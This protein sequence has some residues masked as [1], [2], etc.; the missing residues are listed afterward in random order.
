MGA[1]RGPG[2]SPV[3]SARGKEIVSVGRVSAIIVTR[4][5]RRDIGRTLASVSASC[6]ALHEVIVLDHGSSDGTADYVRCEHRDVVLLDF[7]DNPG[8]GEGNNRGAR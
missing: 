8:F 2:R 7:L 4:N 1:R 3:R 5:N 6:H